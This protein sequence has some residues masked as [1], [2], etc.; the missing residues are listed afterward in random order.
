MVY[1]PP[2]NQTTMSLLT[3]QSVTHAYGTNIVLDGIGFQVDRGARIGLIGPN[4]EG[5]TTLLRIIAGDL[6]PTAGN[7]QRTRGVSTAYLAQDPPAPEGMTVY[8]ACLDVFSELR[9]MEEQL[10]ELTHQV[11]EDHSPALLNKLGHLQTAFEHAGGYTYHNQIETIL[12]GLHFPEDRWTHPLA[13]LSGGQRTRAHLACI[14]LKNPDVLLLDEPTNHL[15]I[16]AVEWLEGFLSGTYQGAV[17]T[18]SHDRYFLDR[19]TTATWDV[20]FG[21]VECYRGNYSTSREQKAERD[22]HRQRQWEQQKEY[23]EKTEAFIRQH[24]SGQRTK[25]AQG[26]RTRLERFKRDMAQEQPVEHSTI[27]LNVEVSGRTGDIAMRATDLTIGYSPEAPLAAAERLEVFRGQ[28]IAIVGGNGVGKTTLLRTL[29]GELDALD[30]EIRHGSNVE[31]GYLSQTHDELD[32][33]QT[34]LDSVLSAA[35]EGTTVQQVRDTLG[36]LLLG[37]LESFQRV[38]ELSGGQRSRLILARLMV[39]DV[40]LLMLDEPTNHLDIPSTEALQEVLKNFSGAVLLVSHDRYLIESVATDIWV[41]EDETVTAVPGGW[42]A[43][44]R[45]IDRKKQEAKEAKQAKLG[46]APKAG[47]KASAKTDRDGDDYRAA[48]RAANAQ[49]KLQKR[50][51]ELEGQIEQIETKLAELHDAISAAGESGDL[52]AIETLGMEYQAAQNVLNLAMEEWE[53][54]GEQLAE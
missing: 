11:S 25:E 9:A 14:L 8:D 3:G 45:W 36:S 28:R 40:S 20:A 50:H 29:L 46:S 27:S 5:K 19:V 39:G 6:E 4:G 47:A 24:I 26:R 31:I 34:A 43:Y 10:N 21:Q 32:P 33:T 30:G 54:T 51:N 15:D 44:H 35:P 1:S 23:I 2:R 18:V 48:R 17:I 41:M 38:D 7:V 49:K 42:E 16:Q 13:E 52:S 37:G 12:S 22:L 53:E